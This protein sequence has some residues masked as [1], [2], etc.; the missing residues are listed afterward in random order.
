[1]TEH[2]YIK[3][4]MALVMLENS[5]RDKSEIHTRHIVDEISKGLRSYRLRPIEDF[6]GKETVLFNYTDEDGSA[7][8]YIFLSPHIITTDMQ[9]RN[10]R[11]SAVNYIS[12][13]KAAKD[14]F[15]QKSEKIGMSEIPIVGEFTSFSQTI[16]RGAAKSTKLK[17]GLGLVATLTPYKPSI[18]NACL[19]P[20]LDVKEMIDFIAVFKRLLF[21]ATDSL[22]VGKVIAEGTKGDVKYHPKRPKICSGNFPNAP[23]SSVMGSIALLGAIGELGKEE[24]YSEKVRHVLDSLR[25]R[26]IYIIRYGDAKSFTFNNCIIELA[27]NSKLSSVVDSIY[28]TR[29]YNQEERN[30]GNKEY[31]KFDLFTSRFLQLFNRPAFKD[32]LSFRAEYSNQTEILFTT[33]FDKMENI[34]RTIIKSAKSLG[35]W[36]N[37]VAYKSATDNTDINLSLQQKKAKTLVELES[38]IFAAKT[39]DALIAQTIT[40][41]GRLSGRDAPSETECFIVATLTGD[42][43]LN[44]AKNLLIAFSRIKSYKGED[45]NIGDNESSKD[46]SPIE[47]YSQI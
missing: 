37:W 2:P 27:K 19:I 1:M 20:D 44:V 22:F 33:Y 11:A 24:E 39:A 29:L 46:N 16:G 10:V 4:G 35:Q 43:T 6:Y 42:I 3:Y 26:P 17:Q 5:L 34:D 28:Y 32:F 38:S 15:L 9:A 30:W 40:R 13:A 41:A 31:E 12:D 18:S 47:D 25:E 23:Y 45:T 7:K 14:T 21:V 36:L 8:N